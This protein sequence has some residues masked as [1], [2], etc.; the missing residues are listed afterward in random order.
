MHVLDFFANRKIVYQLTYESDATCITR[1]RMN[2]RAFT[3]L[4][5]RLEIVGGL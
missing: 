4:C 1:L 2:K 5:T 3:Y